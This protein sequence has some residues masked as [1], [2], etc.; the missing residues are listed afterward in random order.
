[1]TALNIRDIGDERKAALVHEAKLRG[2]SVAQLVRAMIDDL[3]RTAR[4][5]RERAEWI[6]A[7]RPGIEA[8][9]R[10][11]EDGQDPLSDFRTELLEGNVQRSHPA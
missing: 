9:R 4:R 8:E 6:E 7:A 5:E 10:R 11:I 3:V 1:M 2:V